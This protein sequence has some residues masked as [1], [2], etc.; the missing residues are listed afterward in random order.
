VTRQGKLCLTAILAACIITFGIPAAQAG[1]GSDF[2]RKLGDQA[3]TVLGKQN[4]TLTQREAAFRII[5]K[6]QF[7]MPLIGRFALGRY[8]RIASTEQRRDYLN[9][10]TDYVVK[11][12]ANKLGG[13]KNEAMVIISEQPL[14]NKKD[15]LVRTKIT[16]PTGGAIKAIWRVRTRKKQL[17]IIDVMVE[18]IS[19]LVTHRQEF[20]AV[21]Q[22]HGL[23]GLLS[24]LRARVGKLPV[25]AS[26]S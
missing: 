11:S 5:L 14:K 13:Y 7:D 10:F 12:F 24:T 20:A 22:R 19:M 3:M 1:P 9:L 18:G 25:T 23:T 26:K 15:V 4:Q 21:I 2:I 17:R 16:R 8:W 6:K